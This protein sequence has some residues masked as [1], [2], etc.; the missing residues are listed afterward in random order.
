MISSGEV[1]K[2]FTQRSRE[3]EISYSEH[4]RSTVRKTEK[5][6]SWFRTDRLERIEKI[7]IH[8][9]FRLRHAKRC[10]LCRWNIYSLKCS[11]LQEIHSFALRCSV[12]AYIE[13]SAT[14]MFSSTQQ[15]LLLKGVRSSERV[16]QHYFHSVRKVFIQTE[17]LTGCSAITSVLIDTRGRR[18]CLDHTWRASSVSHFQPW[19]IDVMKKTFNEL[20]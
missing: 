4:A 1:W 13:I 15:V 7:S 10:T 8:R 19:I 12:P 6:S 17:V 20:N 11:F 5:V 3:I 16:A 14:W 18:H 9:L 2:T